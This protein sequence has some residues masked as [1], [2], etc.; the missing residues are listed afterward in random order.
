MILVKLKK[1]SNDGNMRLSVSWM[2][3]ERKAAE[4]GWK[5]VPSVTLT[6]GIVIPVELGEWKRQSLPLA[7]SD[8]YPKLFGRFRDYFQMEVRSRTLK[9]KSLLL[10][11]Q[12]FL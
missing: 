12:H 8:P 4:N 6:N 1:L 2:I 9:A 7:V 3:D 11:H 5:I 10:L